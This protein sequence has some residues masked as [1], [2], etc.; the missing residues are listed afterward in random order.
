MLQNA[1]GM[2]NKGIKKTSTLLP[3]Q[4]PHNTKRYVLYKPTKVPGVDSSK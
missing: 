2:K 1:P 3:I 4:Q